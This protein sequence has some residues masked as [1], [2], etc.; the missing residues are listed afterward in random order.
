MAIPAPTRIGVGEPA[1]AVAMVIAVFTALAGFDTK[2]RRA[3]FDAG[4][5]A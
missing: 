2:V 4:A 1:G 3:C 5:V